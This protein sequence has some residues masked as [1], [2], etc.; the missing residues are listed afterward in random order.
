LPWILGGVGLL[1]LILILAIAAG[2]DSTTAKSS[3]G[4]PQAQTGGSR[5]DRMV[6]QRYSELDGKTIKEWMSEQDETD[7][8][9]ERRQRLQSHKKGN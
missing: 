5:S 9:R 3:G 1:A 8:A 7:M 6:N 4:M 2:G